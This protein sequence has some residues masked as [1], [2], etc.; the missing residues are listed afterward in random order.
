MR[1]QIS[2]EASQDCSIAFIEY[3]GILKNKYGDQTFK[4]DPGAICVIGQGCLRYTHDQDTSH[5]ELKTVR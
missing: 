3:A 1:F 2:Q 4:H 5:A